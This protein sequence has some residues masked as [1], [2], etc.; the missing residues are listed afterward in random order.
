MSAGRIIQEGTPVAFRAGLEGR[1]LELVGQPL[2]LLRGLAEQDDGVD[3][4]QM[5]GDRLHLRVAAGQ[6]QAVMER[7]AEQIPE[8]GGQV[9]RLR[10]ISPQLEDVFMDLLERPA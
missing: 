9:S 7:L 1:V 3:G 4:V 6:A 5:F 8:R 2:I 10:P